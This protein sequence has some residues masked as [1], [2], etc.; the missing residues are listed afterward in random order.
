MRIRTLIREVCPVKAVNQSG[1]Q[2]V[3]SSRLASDAAGFVAPTFPESCVEGHNN[4]LPGGVNEEAKEETCASASSYRQEENRNTDSGTSGCVEEKSTTCGKATGQRG[5]LHDLVVQF[6]L[7]WRH[8]SVA[9]I[10]P[11]RTF[12]YSNH[13]LP[14]SEAAPTAPVPVRL[15]LARASAL[16]SP[17]LE[18]LLIRMQCNLADVTYGAIWEIENKRF[19]LFADKITGSSL[20]LPL[21]DFGVQSVRLHIRESRQKFGIWEDL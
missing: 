21:N 19:V 10:D 12:S 4:F 18:E 1:F 9:P 16:P 17:S 8:H 6:F 3:P 2:V 14:R 20:V 15:P 5:R 13:N 11:V 7:N